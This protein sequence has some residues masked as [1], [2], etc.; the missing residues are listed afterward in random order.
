MVSRLGWGDVWRVYNY[1]GTATHLERD[2]TELPLSSYIFKHRK[3]TLGQILFEKTNY[4]ILCHPLPTVLRLTTHTAFVDIYYSKEALQFKQV[5][6]RQV[7]PSHLF[8]R[9]G[10]RKNSIL[11]H[12]KSINDEDKRRAYLL[13]NIN[14]HW[15]AFCPTLGF[16]KRKWKQKVT[17]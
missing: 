4:R 6:R 17:N 10:A 15:V 1:V 2:I 8:R 14:G 3:C 7:L 5:V 12:L 9:R 16:I 13:I 11:L